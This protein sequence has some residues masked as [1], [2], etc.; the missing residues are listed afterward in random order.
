MNVHAEHTC[1][2]CGYRFT[3]E[4]QRCRGCPIAIG[5]ETICC[6]HCHYTF[7]PGSRLLG[8]LHRLFSGKNRRREN[9]G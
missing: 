8:A 4:P 2:L 5:C 9:P 6:P 3:E 1:P 7:A